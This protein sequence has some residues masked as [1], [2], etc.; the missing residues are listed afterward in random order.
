MNPEKKFKKG[1]WVIVISTGRAPDSWEPGDAVTNNGHKI[2]DIFQVKFDDNK[3][4]IGT[5]GDNEYM[6]ESHFSEAPGMRLVSKP[7][8]CAT[9]CSRCNY[10]MRIEKKVRSSN[11]ERVSL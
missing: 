9:G 8:G 1:D 11:L 7:C 10:T 5:A 6:H 2:G 3:Q 4:G